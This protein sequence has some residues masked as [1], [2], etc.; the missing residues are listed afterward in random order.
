M[1]FFVGKPDFSIPKNGMSQIQKIT[2]GGIEQAILIQTENITNPIILF[3]HGGPSMPVPGVSNRGKD[4]AF[5]TNT[6]RL[7]QHFTL[8]FWDQ[9]GTGKSYSKKIPK[10]TMHLSQFVEDANEI[11]DYLLVRFHQDKL[12]LIAHS[13]GTMIGLSLVKKYP[14]KVHSYTGFSQ[15]TNWTENDKLCYRWL[16]DKA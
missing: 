7:V 13:W 12:H 3:L 11:I 1:K 9:R 14:E 5:V 2:V 4:Y 10:E 8:V 6:K 15:V 16:L